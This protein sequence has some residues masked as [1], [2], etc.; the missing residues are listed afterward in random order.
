MLRVALI[1][2][3]LLGTYGDAGNGLVLVERAKARGID[4]ELVSVALGDALPDA[5]I[6]LL[7]GGEDGPQR[8]ATEA[9]RGDGS[10]AMRHKD[11]SVIFAVCAGLQILGSSFA[12][13]GDVAYEGLGLVDLTTTRGER[14]RVGE[15]RV[16]VAG[17]A[18]V[19]FENHGG[20]TNL[21]EIAAL[22][23]VKVGFGNDGDLDGFLGARLYGTY[24]HGPVLAI[25]PW[26]A[27]RVLA[28]A[29]GIALDPLATVA[30]ELYKARVA[31]VN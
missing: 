13:Q 18:L 29:L 11:G 26:L 15:I 10:L 28:E 7:G 9:L 25:N 17:Q 4:S 5:E 22:G 16:E 6:Y 3:E 12:V 27:D 24:A 2:P 30:D 14:R 8:Q 23:A 19:G 31:A 21:G 1:Y 20:V